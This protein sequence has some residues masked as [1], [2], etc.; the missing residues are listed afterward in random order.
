[1]YAS[2]CF[3]MN[4]PWKAL[5]ALI[6]P[7]VKLDDV[8]RPVN[9]GRSAAQVDLDAVLDPE[10]FEDLAE[11]AVLDLVHGLDALDLAVGQSNRIV[12]QARLERRHEMADMPVYRR[13]QNRAAVL[14]EKLRPVCPSAEKT[15]PERCLTDD[16][17]DFFN[18]AIALANIAGPLG[19]APLEKDMRPCIKLGLPE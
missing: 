19:C 6:S 12:E 7:T 13:P 9:E 2:S 14:E 5:M 1:M 4:R 15:D 18:E 3:E 8:P 17:G 16:H 10:R 11:G